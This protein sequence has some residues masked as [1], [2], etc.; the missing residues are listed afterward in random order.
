[1][2]TMQ[3]LHR[4]IKPHNILVNGAGADSHWSYVAE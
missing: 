1:M 3:K 4:D 2:W